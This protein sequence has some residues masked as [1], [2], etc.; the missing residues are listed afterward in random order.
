MALCL[1]RH[2]LVEGR[3]AVRVVDVG[4]SGRAGI[5]QIA[6]DSSNAFVD[7]DSTSKLIRQVSGAAAVS[8]RAGDGE[9]GPTTPAV[10]M[11]NDIVRRRRP[12]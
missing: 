10:V 7:D 6:A 1:A 5:E 2:L 11:A 3:T 12:Y 4:G 9:R 8:L